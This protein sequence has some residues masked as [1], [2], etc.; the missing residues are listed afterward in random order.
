MGL[1]AGNSRSQI[2]KDARPPR[3][4]ADAIKSLS[5]KGEWQ[6]SSVSN[7]PLLS[8]DLLSHYMYHSLLL[9]LIHNVADNVLSLDFERHS[10]AFIAYF[11]QAALQKCPVV[12]GP[13]PPLRVVPNVTVC[14]HGPS[15]A[16]QALIIIY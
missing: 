7:S 16:N 9:E 15:T 10:R 1:L 2:E 5:S 13:L 8:N 3:A 11:K 4:G 6:A 14:Q 12:I